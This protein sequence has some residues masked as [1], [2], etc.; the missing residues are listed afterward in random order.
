MFKAFV[1]VMILTAVATLIIF[2][3]RRYV[4]EHNYGD[5]KISVE[6]TKRVH[7]R[8]SSIPLRVLVTNQSDE[9][10]TFDTDKKPLRG[11]SVSDSG[12]SDPRP[13]YDVVV[14]MGVWHKPEQ[15]WIW[16]QNSGEAPSSKIVLQP[17]ET[18]LLL[19][20]V[21]QP[22][23]PHLYVSVFVRFAD[24]EYPTRIEVEPPK[25]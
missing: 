11:D 6:S 8:G 3:Q 1:V 4:E 19:D 7:S 13:V 23:K 5:L 2:S 21:W 22:S 16:S 10:Y 12:L 17:H 20:T 18:K 24:I 15:F 25:R 9:I 14:R